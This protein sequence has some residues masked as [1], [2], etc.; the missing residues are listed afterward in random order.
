[1]NKVFL[2][3]RLTKAPEVRSTQNG[4]SVC[5]FT[6]AVDKRKKED[7]ADFLPI[8]VWGTLAEVCGKYLDKG[9]QVAVAGEIHTRSYEAKDGGKRY[10]TEITA[11]SVEFMGTKE[12][13]AEPSADIF[14]DVP[15]LVEEEDLPF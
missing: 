2:T 9:R 8:V 5:T 10:V 12:K 1:M 14:K 15:T 3:G 7:G 6:L 4:K 11:D 13:A